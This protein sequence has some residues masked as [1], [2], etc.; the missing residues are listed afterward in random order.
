MT[1]SLPP[2]PF[3]PRTASP[4]PSA[5]SHITGQTSPLHTSVTDELPP[6]STAT[7]YRHLHVAMSAPTATATTNDGP[8][9]TNIATSPPWWHHRYQPP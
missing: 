7:T 6:T 5:T 9:T 3:P 4:I 8:T 1:T 2:N